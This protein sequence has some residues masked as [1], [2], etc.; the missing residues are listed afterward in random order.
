MV[1]M[2]ECGLEYR[3]TGE[4][5]YV[6]KLPG[7]DYITLVVPVDVMSPAAKATYP[8]VIARLGVVHDYKR[9]RKNGSKRWTRHAGVD[10]YF[11][12]PTD[13][14]DMVPK[15]GHSYVP[16]I[17]N[18]QEFVLSVTSIGVAT[19][20]TDF[21]GRLAA[22]TAGMSKTMIKKIQEVALSPETLRAIGFVLP[23]GSLI[24]EN[25]I[26]MWREMVARKMMK[27]QKDTFLCP[28]KWTSWAGSKYDVV[29]VQ[30]K[31]TSGG[32]DVA[33]DGSIY[34][35]GRI[36]AKHV[37]WLATAEKNGH[38]VPQPDTWTAL[39]VQV[40]VPSFIANEG[41]TA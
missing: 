22:T 7:T 41:V 2:R 30:E 33:L 13:R 11:V 35:R 18:G 34:S 17:V 28:H 10:L 1:T 8:N 32:W 4:A 20:C 15:K 9:C 39:G 26:P 23:T 12:I 31:S 6:V 5:D 16:V 24:Y 27:V 38:V 19:G 25:Q 36:L 14:I 37:D 21:V 3:P 40:D 29:S